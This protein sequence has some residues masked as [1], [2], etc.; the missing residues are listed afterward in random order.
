MNI[1]F[2][3]LHY[4]VEDITQECIDYILQQNYPKL[5]IVVID[6]CSANGSYEKLLARYVNEN[7]LYFASI[8]YNLGF[9]KANDLGYQI[10]KHKF[11]AECIAIIN[12]DLMIRDGYFCK[13]LEDVINTY[14]FDILGPDIIT[15]EGIHQNPL[16]ECVTNKIDLKKLIIKTRLKLL[17]IP[18]LYNLL[19]YETKKKN[20]N[21]DCMARLEDIPLHGSC[22]VFTKSFIDKTEFPFYPETFLYGE[23]DILYFLVCKKELKTMFCPEL[24]VYHK[25]DVSTDN[26][27]SKSRKAKRI[28]ELKNSLN[29]LKILWKLY[30]SW[31]D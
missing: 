10:A 12:N 16:N 9:A 1:V 17:L 31:P 15:M 18:L 22:L 27:F 14:K 8:E 21:D 2:V 29:S 19:P 30:N 3:V 4:K 6:N 11:N 20:I 28:F 23:E 25:E 24:K 7:R 13:K 5:K 26:V